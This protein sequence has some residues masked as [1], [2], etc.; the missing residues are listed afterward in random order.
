MNDIQTKLSLP[1]HLLEA[2]RRR[3]EERQR[4]PVSTYR[5][6]LHAGFT[7]RNAQAIVPYLAKLGISD[8]YCSPFLCARPGSTHGYDICSHNQLNPE[9]GGEEDFQTFVDELMFHD[10]G[11]ILDFVPNHMAADPG[12]NPWWRSVLEDGLSSPFASFFDIDWH[13][14]K[15]ELNG[16]VLLPVLGDHYGIVLER[17]ELQLT[18]DQGALV[19]RYHDRHW[20]VDPGQYPKVLRP[21]LGTLQATV[22]GDDSDLPEFL[23]VLTALEHLPGLHEADPDRRAERQREKKV[24][25]ERLAQVAARST[26]I[27]KYIEDTL[28]A[29]NGQPGQ[30]RSFDRLHELLEALPYRLAYWRTAS[31]EINY[32][33]FFDINDLVGMRMEEPAFFFAAHELVLRLIRERKVTGLRLDH[34]DGLFDPAGYLDALQE[35][36]LW[37]WTADLIPK[38]AP[39]KEQRRQVRKLRNGDSAPRMEDGE[40]RIEEPSPFRSS[41]LD[42]RSSR[43]I[44]HSPFTAPLFVVV[45]KILSGNET[46]PGSWPIHGTSGYD[47]LNDLNRLFVDP[48]NM[49]ALT[50]AYE[51][52]TGQAQPLADVIYECKKLI[53]WTAMASELN[54]LAHALNQLSEGNRRARDFTLNNLRE[55]LREV[56][57][58]FPVYRTY[59]SAAGATEND[60]HMIDLALTRAKQ[61]NPLMEPLVF[62]FLRQVL[63]PANGRA[64]VEWPGVSGKTPLTDLDHSAASTH[65]AS[66]TTH[67]SLLT[68]H[69]SATN[70]DDY[71][72]RL[73]FAMKFQQY[74]G[75]VQAKGLEDTACYRYNRLLS[76]N[77]VGGDP[78]RFGG[79]PDQFHEANRQRHERWPYAMLATATHDTKRGEDAR[80]RL[81]VLSEIPDDWRRAIFQLA[82]M[83][84]GHRTEVQGEKAPDRNDEYLFYQALLGAWPA[85]PLGTTHRFASTELVQRM[86]D[87]MLK[88]VKEAK[89]HSSWINPNE[90]YD[91]AVADFVDKTLAG[92][93]AARFLASF[94][95]FQQQ[96]AKLGMIN[97]LSQVLL[98]LVSPGVP[99]I[100]Q[101]TELWDFSLVDP[102]N[103]RPVDFAHRLSLLNDLEPLLK[104][105][106]PST[107]RIQSLKEI[108]DCWEDGRVKLFLVSLGLRLRRKY[109]RLFLQGEYLALRA[110]GEKAE[111]VVAIVRRHEGLL[112]LAVA[113][114]L[115]AGL[116]QDLSLPVGSDVWK[117][118]RLD[119]HAS[120]HADAFHN[121]L[122]GEHVPV[123]R[124]S[125]QASVKLADLLTVCPVALLEAKVRSAAAD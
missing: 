71:R 109:P 9:L 96:V 53:T 113:P 14:I 94:L 88:A 79:I 120:I 66:L 69:H 83:N 35:A 74:T 86:R 24:A 108:L 58:C 105:Q 111:H 76:L 1:E 114:R 64:S 77:E 43:L 22:K 8:C 56:V 50:R 6:Q 123:R 18:F 34:L 89:I 67:H 2:V 75:P 51:H 59:V 15:P 124:E 99:D 52:F 98:K 100:Y 57:A 85:E 36:V 73:E 95:P 116:V 82:R 47:F 27:R 33:R 45:E 87:Y 55:A 12:M 70:E 42:P 102:D 17:G 125:D 5:L 68:P 112:I 103:R 72:Q 106:E 65:D 78:Q 31:D 119:L 92:P 11:Q 81:N 38:D 90:A 107:T 16:K 23:S 19:L 110:T 118:T 13:P 44:H 84:A 46:L 37:E 29:M 60:Q 26:P 63:L 10:L 62:D 20:P 122:T 104:F 39:A 121:L 7:F 28:R 3:I 97:S 21:G 61:R 4:L 49:K 30:P 40:S 117:D 32:R 93:R 41:I 101:G 54:I 91:K 115:V 80:A 48:K 25:R